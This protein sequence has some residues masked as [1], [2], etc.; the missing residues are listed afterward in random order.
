MDLATHQRKLLGLFRSTYRPSAADDIY[1][2]NVAQSRDLQEGRRNILLWR[3]WVL[4]RTCALTVRLLRQRNL[5]DATLAAFIERNNI[6]PFR[7]TQAP[8]FLEA[9][10]NYSDGLIRS[11]AQFE[12]ALLRVRQGDTATYVIPWSLDPYPVLDSLAN[13]MPLRDRVSEGAYE[14]VVSQN[15][16]YEFQIRRLGTHACGLLPDGMNDESVPA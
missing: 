2:H 11:V 3:T 12:L 6:S 1:I 9:L 8:R 16:P 10:S 5:F 13:D 4:E 14:I 15:L 7:E